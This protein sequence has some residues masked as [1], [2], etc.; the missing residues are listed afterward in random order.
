LPFFFFLLYF[1]NHVFFFFYFVLFDDLD[2][3]TAI[4]PI[5]MAVAALTAP[6]IIRVLLFVVGAPVGVMDIVTVSMGDA[7]WRY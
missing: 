7:L 2:E 3:A 5:I 6:I 4:A 1:F